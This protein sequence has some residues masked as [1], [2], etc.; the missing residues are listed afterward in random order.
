MTAYTEGDN[1]GDVLKWEEDSRYSR[2]IV[3]LGGTDTVTIGSV[4]GR[5]TA[6][7]VYGSLDAASTIG[8][9]TAA[10]I[11]L[12][13]KTTTAAATVLVA[14]R[15]CVVDAD[16]LNWPSGFTS[17]DKVAPSKVL[18]DAGIVIRDGV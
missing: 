3:P 9:Q 17:V 7:G 12:E 2:E 5:V 13:N 14:R 1:I 15:A 6:T 11:S 4:L 16:A 18:N 8:L 10:A